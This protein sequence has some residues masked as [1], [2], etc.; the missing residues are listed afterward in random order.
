M[1]GSKNINRLLLYRLVLVRLKELG[2]DT[3]FSYNLGKEAGVTP[4]Q[5]RKDFSKFGI[6]GN[7]KG[8]YNINELTDKINDIFQKDKLQKVILVGYGNIGTALISYKGFYKNMIK[9][10]AAFDIDPAKYKKKTVIPVYPMAKL[11]EVISSLDVKTAIIS[12]PG[13]V[14]QEV[15]SQL[16]DSGILGI[17]NFSPTILKVPPHVLIQNIQIGNALE[18]LIYHI[19]RADT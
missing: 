14:A 13:Q 12:V 19:I 4:E 2:F 11:N 1:N 6:K 16:V 17:L 9:I 7:K 5:V 15:C 10:V 3:V 8:G 18:S